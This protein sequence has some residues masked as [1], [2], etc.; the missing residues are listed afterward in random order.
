MRCVVGL[1]LL[2]CSVADA[3]I[4]PVRWPDAS[5]LCA[6]MTLQQCIE[7]TPGGAELRVVRGAGANPLYHAIPGTLTITRPLVLSVEPGVDAVLADGAD[8]ECDLSAGVGNCHIEGFVLRRGKIRLLAPG[9]SPGDVRILRNRIGIPSRSSATAAIEI[10]LRGAVSMSNWEVQIANNVLHSTGPSGANGIYVVNGVRARAQIADNL[11]ESN[12]A[13]GMRNGIFVIY[14][15]DGEL[16]IERNIVRGSTD[17]T[18]TSSPITITL[19]G[20]MSAPIRVADN[21]IRSVP[22]ATGAGIGM[23]LGFPGVSTARIVNNSVIEG[24]FGI[25][26][27]ST[28]RADTYEL[29]NNLVVGQSNTAVIFSG[30]PMAALNNTFNALFGNAAS[31]VGFV[32]SSTN[33]FADPRIENRDFPRPIAGSPLIQAGSFSQ[34]SARAGEPPFV[35][36]GGDPRRGNALAIDIGAFQWHRDTIFVHEANTENSDGNYTVL[37]ASI[38]ASNHPVA[39][40]LVQ[41]S[42]PMQHDQAVGVWRPTPAR[43]ALYHEDAATPI[44][45]R[46]F[47][48]ASYEAAAFPHDADL[49]NT[50]GGCTRVPGI[51]FNQRDPNSVAIAMHRFEG[52]FG[53]LYFPEPFSMVFDADWFICTDTPSVIP[54]GL[55]FHVLDAPLRSPNGFT[56][57]ALPQSAA[58]VPLAHR[59]L[60]GAACALPVVGR[61]HDT[62]ALSQVNPRSLAVQH[63]PP[64]GPGAPSR[65]VVHR[66]GTSSEPFPM[67]AA[68]NTVLS[69]AQALRCRVDADLLRNGFE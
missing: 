45:G 28:A 69:G 68:F 32:P 26:L 36:V 46:R 20:P 48:V 16:R 40:P 57:R 24:R 4:V 6:G 13:Q 50:A 30:A 2:W 14:Q 54:P 7:A 8:I 61:G 58:E 64:R 21:W 60:D 52:P 11:I 59:L 67:N 33:I 43:L 18:A 66:V 19:N 34:W 12:H 53:N 37:P 35:D 44:S 47:I 17:V 55:R 25:S 42:M 5:G 51:G 23:V 29:H 56:T 49:G 38:D 65:W 27:A 31:A 1:W 39:V 62:T 10:D 15:N 41:G 22:D 3:G 63:E 9:A